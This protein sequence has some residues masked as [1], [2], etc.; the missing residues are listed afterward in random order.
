MTSDSLDSSEDDSD[1]ILAMID[2]FDINKVE[3]YLVYKFRTK[4]LNSKGKLVKRTTLPQHFG[5]LLITRTKNPFEWIIEVAR[6]VRYSDFERPM[7]KS[8]GDLL[9][10]VMGIDDSFLERK[11][12]YYLL[13]KLSRIFR[14]NAETKGKHLYDSKVSCIGER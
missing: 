8:L 2:P 3:D 9:R 7:I 12:F 6:K 1:R 5:Y 4:K 14:G 10:V 11:D 13:R